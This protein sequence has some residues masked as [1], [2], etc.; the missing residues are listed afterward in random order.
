MVRHVECLDL[1]R[2]STSGSIVPVKAAAFSGIAMDIERY[3]VYL[4]KRV[5]GDAEVSCGLPTPSQPLKMR[6]DKG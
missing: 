3:R 2:S 4:R 5:G 6:R 1:E